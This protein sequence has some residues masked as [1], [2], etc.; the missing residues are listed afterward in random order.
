M[1]WTRNSTAKAT[2]GKAESQSTQTAETDHVEIETPASVDEES[3][4]ET[5]PFQSGAV[6]S[7][8]AVSGLV[9]GGATSSSSSGGKE[10]GAE[11][12][13]ATD[14]NNQI[15]SRPAHSS[16][17]GTKRTRADRDAR[18]RPA[19]E[20]SAAGE[21]AGASAVLID[22]NFDGDSEEEESG[23]YDAYDFDPGSGSDH[24]LPDPPIPPA[25]EEFV[26]D[27]SNDDDEEDDDE[28]QGALSPPFAPLSRGNSPVITSLPEDQATNVPW[29]PQKLSST[30]EFTHKITNYSQKRE[31][32]CK[33]AEYSSTTV[34]AFGNR[35]RLIVYVNGNGR[36][37][38]HHLS[39]FLQVRNSFFRIQF[40]N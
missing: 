3:N 26:D 9:D 12:Q 25:D 2:D 19:K 34:D 8:S 4:S 14:E 35:W 39:L 30:C 18:D 31:S 1:R 29:R 40:Q 15:M 22:G 17:T 32:G 7:S 36:A 21:G 16:S 5:N 33:K 6:P 13:S 20:Y 10:F 28:D 38:N 23:G 11:Q 24:A 37:S 27:I